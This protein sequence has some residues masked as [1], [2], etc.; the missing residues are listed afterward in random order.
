MLTGNQLRICRSILGYTTADMGTKLYLTKQAVSAIENG[1]TTKLS[2]VYYYQ[3]LIEKLAVD[4][5]EVMDF[6]KLC[7]T[8]EQLDTHILHAL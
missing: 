3:L 7:D 1:K 2:S 4:N 5:Q 6:I 8:E